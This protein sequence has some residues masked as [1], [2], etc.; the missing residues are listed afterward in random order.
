M[1]KKMEHGMETTIQGL[2][3]SRLSGSG[4]KVHVPRCLGF[5]GNS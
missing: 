1:E 5:K 2:G 3:F 4:F